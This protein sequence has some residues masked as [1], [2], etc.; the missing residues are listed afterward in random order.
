VLGEESAREQLDDRLDRSDLRKDTIRKGERRQLHERER[1]EVVVSGPL[2]IDSGHS[3]MVDNEGS[4]RQA[5][6]ERR[7]VSK[8]RKKKANKVKKEK[9]NSVAK[10]PDVIDFLMNAIRTVASMALVIY[11][12]WVISLPK[13]SMYIFTPIGIAF[14]IG[15]VIVGRRIWKKN[16]KRRRNGKRYK[17]MDVERQSWWITALAMISMIGGGTV[18]MMLW[19]THLLAHYW[20]ITIPVAF[21]TLAGAVFSPERAGEIL[22]DFT[23]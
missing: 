3:L 7:T 12:L 17:F 4:E 2:V 19:M 20:Y 14:F 15:F 16:E 21:L 9:V 8:V 1:R 6:D 11:F 13:R 22:E 18:L 5:H 23:P 10:R